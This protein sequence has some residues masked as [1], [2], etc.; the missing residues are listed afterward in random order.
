MPHQQV[1]AASAV[2]HYSPVQPAELEMAQPIEIQVAV[3]D[4]L[5]P[6]VVSMPN[7]CVRGCG[8]A[9]S[10]CTQYA[11]LVRER[12]GYPVGSQWGDARDWPANAIADG[13]PVGYAPVVG[14]VAI[15]GAGNYGHAMVVQAVYP[16]GSFKVV[17]QNYDFRGGIR[18][19]VVGSPAGLT[20]IY[21]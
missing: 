16:D 13:V 15:N 17:E 14:A 18:E 6:Q 20:F 9:A 19:R 21:F 4:P 5:Q 8:Y 12:M 11:A 10:N 3:A 7:P 2:E 1:L